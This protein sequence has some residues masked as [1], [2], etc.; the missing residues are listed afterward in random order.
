MIVSKFID[1][2]RLIPKKHAAPASGLIDLISNVSDEST[3]LENTSHT[4]FSHR[5]VGMLE[6]INIFDAVRR[7]NI[8][9]HG[10]AHDRFDLSLCHAD[11][12]LAGFVGGDDITLDDVSFCGAK[13]AAA[14]GTDDE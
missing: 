3:I 14:Q 2:S 9:D 11:V 8:H 6:G 7:K 13:E 4:C 1:H 10:M 5:L 12:Q